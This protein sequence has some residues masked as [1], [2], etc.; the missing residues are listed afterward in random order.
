MTKTVTQ[1]VLLDK[2][3]DGY[4]PSLKARFVNWY[5]NKFNIENRQYGTSKQWNQ[6]HSQYKQSRPI[7]YA[8][9]QKV[10]PK[11]FQILN[12]PFRKISDV[13]YWLHNTFVSK[14][15]VLQTTLPIGQYCEI[16]HRMLL[17]NFNTLVIFVEHEYAWSYIIGNKELYKK[18]NYNWINKLGL[19]RWVSA[20][21]GID[22]LQYL[23]D[24]HSDEP[25]GINAKEILELYTWWKNYEAN[26]YELT[27]NTEFDEFIA[28]MSAKYGSVFDWAFGGDEC[29]TEEERLE[30]TAVCE[31]LIANE[32][33]EET[34]VDD[35]LIRLMKV[36]RSLWS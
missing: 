5:R 9:E 11:F 4:K 16:D 12:Y 34:I 33:A 1:P 25:C 27:P 14:T 32:D 36:R 28:R 35:M 24:N 8:L 31:N 2:K 29:L 6:W 15:H 20:Q 23:I 30:Y 18:Y 19:R 7:I 13:R 21:A 17:A 22:H 26:E 10:F 3:S